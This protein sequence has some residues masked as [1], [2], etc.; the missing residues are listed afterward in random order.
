MKK[1]YKQLFNCRLLAFSIVAASVQLSGASHLAFPRIGSASVGI[2]VRD[3]ATGKD[4]ISENADKLMTPASIL[5][6][7]TAA[8]TLMN[9]SCDKRFITETVVEGECDHDGI[10]HGNIV[11]KGAAD[12]T[13]CSDNFPRYS[14]LSDSI[15]SR[16]QMAGVNSIA[17]RIVVDSSYLQEPGPGRGWEYS[18][19]CYSYGAG[20]YA[21][22][23]RDNAC[24]DRAMSNP[25][26]EFIGDVIRA[27]DSVGI[28][29][30]SEYVDSKH[31]SA[32]P[33]Y[34][35]SSPFYGE[36]VDV[37][38]EQS[39]NLYAEGL[40]RA[41]APGGTI[42]DALA[43]EMSVIETLGLDMSSLDAHDGSGLSRQNAVTPGFMADLL[44]AMTFSDRGEEYVAV[45]PK[46]GL[47][48]TVKRFL[49]NT[50]LEGQLVLKSGSMRGV[51]TFAGYKI[52][53]D[54]RPTHVVV[55]MVNHFSCKRAAVRK[56]MSDFLLRQFRG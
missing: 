27:L 8:A 23:F 3:L 54:G 50:P 6:C 13:L 30:V 37:M 22:N 52:N 32:I 35:H 48:G 46:A 15:A 9:N 1:I 5:K 45:F 33:L 29:F 55:I 34:V 38:M 7:V 44:E 31:T 43:K 17:G 41:L 16:L 53:G 42:D 10:L 4:V 47:E 28:H 40:L 21:L 39:Q 26:N 14:G 25:Q 49:N 11:V 56:A 24:L 19:L 12:P 20:L 2:V 18:D 36:I 51:Q